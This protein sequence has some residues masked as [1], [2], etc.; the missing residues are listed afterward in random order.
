MIK[1][2][3]IRICLPRCDEFLSLRTG[4]AKVDPILFGRIT[5]YSEK[6]RLRGHAKAL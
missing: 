1:D 5:R 2:A 3:I 6:A 4:S